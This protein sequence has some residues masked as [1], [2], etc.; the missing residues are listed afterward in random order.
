MSS[1][2]LV[3][4]PEPLLGF[5]FGQQME[6]PKDGLFL[7]GPL[8][9][10]SN[11]AEM[12]IGIVGTEAGIDCFR[13]WAKRIRGHIPSANAAAAHHAS[14]PGFQAVFGTKW[15]ETAL[16]ELIV[17]EAKLA[18]AIRIENRH[19]AIYD[20]VS[21]FEEPI[22]K[23]LRQNE[24]PPTVWFVV[25]PEEIH[26]YGRPKS[27]V[28][29]AER[30]QS[31]SLFNRKTARKIMQTGSLFE[32]ERVA[33]DLYRFEVNFH[34]QLKA[35][36][37]E[38]QVVLQIVRETTLT[39]EKFVVD[40]RQ[41]RTPQD[42]ATVAWNLCSTAFFKA[43]GKPW[44]L[45]SVREG[46]CYVG[47]VFKKDET[48]PESGNACC[49]AQMFLDSGDGVV[50]RG[51]VGPWYSK[52]GEEF[53]LST[54][55]A[56]QLMKLVVDAYAD[57]HGK[58][59]TELFIHGKTRFNNE[60]WEGFCSVVAPETNLVGVRIRSTADLK[61]YRQGKK[62]VL[63]GTAMMVS[64]RRGYLWT[65]GFVS[66]LD[67]YPGWETPNPLSI[68]ITRGTADLQQVM[69]DVL[70]L[71]K[72][73]FNACVFADGLPVTLKFADAVGEILT[74][75]PVSDLPPLPFRHYI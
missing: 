6:H 28:P 21:L 55:K 17:D 61:L 42:P 62:P 56:A 57:M 66:R 12:R 65:K 24:A 51:A 7:F 29:R 73:N 3:Q 32:E 46:V 14:W 4:L 9:D 69:T 8:A 34:H 33:A 48:A 58:P 30:G 72:V 45:A 52:V 63:R 10:N 35:R 68:E 71:T 47:L 27:S 38:K 49:G 31:T 22:R 16:V 53:H 60:E 70:G 19:E 43:S 5:G 36:L 40:G 1:G 67:T 50:F 23:N 18:K 20:S 11:P 74:A 2:T 39:P 25:I 41:I 54:E 64:D 59:P 13:E 75:A 37:L 26:R 15:P 44:R